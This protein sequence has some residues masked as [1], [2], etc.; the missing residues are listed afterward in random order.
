MG[1]VLPG[2]AGVRHKAARWPERSLM[3]GER[4]SAAR[5]WTRLSPRTGLYVGLML[6]VACGEPLPSAPVEAGLDSTE[7]ELVAF[8]Q[9]MVRSAEVMPASALHRGRLG[10]AYDANGFHEAAAT[11]YKQAAAL[12]P[13]A[14]NWPYFAALALAR[15]NRL[16]DA[17][18]AIGQAI[19]IDS[20]Y[21][22]AW[23]WRASWLL[24]KDQHADAKEAYEEALSLSTDLATHAAATLGIARVLLR[25]D[26]PS[27]AVVLLEKLTTRITHPTVSKLLAS[28]QRRLGRAATVGGVAGEARPLTWPDDRQR[29]RAAYVR[30]FS[31]R[32]LMAE[33]LLRD[34]KP[35]AALEILEALRQKAPEDPTLLNNLGFAYKQLGRSSD[36]FDLLLGAVSANPDYPL[37]HFNVA[38]MY[39]NRNDTRNALKHFT[40]ALDL[41]PDMD[42]A[43][44][45]RISLLTRMER[46]EEALQGLDDAAGRA[47]PEPEARFRAGMLA[48]ALERWPL[49]ITRLRKAVQ[50][51]PG[52]ARGHLFLG[53]SL[54]EAGQ[55]EE[56]RK[57]VDEAQALGL[58]AEVV[59]ARERINSLERHQ[60]P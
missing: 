15:E 52:N 37:F 22:P 32:M 31:G 5:L 36:A 39:E 51:E 33:N 12:D 47:I 23:L 2:L 3:A 4:L 56:A 17:L 46:Y 8:L 16:D 40:R 38:V 14:F 24:E 7:P 53:R 11:T 27:E 49:A 19:D 30:G 9:E 35:Q 41:D 54:G 43:A 29:A 48:G 44:A 45:R 34:Q 55:F 13:S 59:A 26:N 42:D 28:S 57:A 21:A 20:S 6:L 25:Q 58:S 18:V 10:M 50:L 60:Q 1:E